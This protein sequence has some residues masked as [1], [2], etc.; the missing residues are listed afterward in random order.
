VIDRRGFVAAG[1][2]CI[3]A[4]IAGGLPLASADVGRKRVVIVNDSPFSEKD[5]ARQARWFRQEGWV[6]GQ[7]LSIE[8][9][10]LAE[11]RDP[12]V[13]ESRAREIVA[14]KPDVILILDWDQ[15]LLFP[16]LTKE[17]PIVFVNFG[18]DPVRLGFVQSVSHPGGNI[19]GTLVPFVSKAWSVARELRSGM[20]R[21]A[22][23]APNDVP[24]IFVAEFR[25]M[26]RAVASQLRMQTVELLV[27]RDAKFAEIERM[28]RTAKVDAVDVGIGE[29]FPWYRDLVRFLERSNI[30]GI[31]GDAA[32]VRAGGLIAVHPDTLTGFWE[33]V[34]IAAHILGGAKPADTP[35]ETVEYIHTSINLRTAKA[36]GIEIPAAVRTGANLVFE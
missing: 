10:S 28:I 5:I 20:K 33:A 35:V 8:Y 31:W 13:I 24:T 29:D 34:R 4:A 1:A 15:L 23:L 17:I 12:Q 16:R 19:T 32:D 3:I 18:C 6:L 21:I 30:V 2:A 7:N 22:I 14:S 11:L 36:M 26:Y 27:S 25:E 9:A